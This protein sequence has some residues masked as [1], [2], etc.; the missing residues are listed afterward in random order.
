MIDRL[1]LV[2][3]G[4]IGKRHLRIA[5]EMLP[6]ADIRILR[7]RQ[8]Y[9][10]VENSNG[11]FSLLDDALAFKPQAVIISNPAP[12]HLPMAMAF[13]NIGCHLLVEKPL[14]DS[15]VGIAELKAL[16][17][18]RRIILQ[19]GYNLRFLP[20]LDEFRTRIASGLIGRVLSV[21][22]EIGQFLPSWR[23]DA[24]YR[25]TVTAQR[26]L[27]GGVLSELSHELD[28]LR[29]VFG[30]VVWVNASL[31]RQSSLDIDVE[32][33]AHLILGFSQRDN[34]NAF[35]ATLNMDFI[36]HDTTRTCIAIGDRGSIRWNG[37]TGEIEEL[38]AGSTAWCKTFHHAHQRDDSYRTQWKHFLACINSKSQPLVGIED[39]VAVLEIIHAARQSSQLN[40]ARTVV[41][42]TKA[43]I[44]IGIIL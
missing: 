5:R 18:K 32:D 31:H 3:H 25:Q 27:G 24:D 19:L 37:I 29:W 35:I 6:H 15:L 30:D 12:F 44:G 7:H 39:G 42:H 10:E 8:K 9:E 21:R 14:A 41:H 16:V 22:S 2:G 38:L 26:D 34:Q 4:S 20:S 11:C 33:T 23:P 40:G 43:E 36:R 13:A 28:Y 17:E 1:L